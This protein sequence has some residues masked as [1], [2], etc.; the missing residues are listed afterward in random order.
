MMIHDADRPRHLHCLQVIV[1]TT[2]IVH[3]LVDEDNNE[4]EDEDR[5]DDVN[6]NI[7]L[8][9]MAMMRKRTATHGIA[10]LFESAG[11]KKATV[12]TKQFGRQSVRASLASESWNLMENMETLFPMIR[13][14]G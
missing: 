13:N 2:G 14:L 8:M 5:D 6:I 10:F 9:L 3:L 4:D 12:A 1:G 7:L 11:Q